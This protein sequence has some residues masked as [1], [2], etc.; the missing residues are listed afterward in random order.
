MRPTE[1]SALMDV[2]SNGHRSLSGMND[3]L[4]D[5]LRSEVGRHDRLDSLTSMMNAAGN[6]TR[7]RILYLLWRN[8]EVRVNDLASILDVTTPAIS[9]QLKKLRA[10]RL[11]RTRRDAQTVYYRLNPD[12][13]F[14]HALIEF[15]H[16]LPAPVS[17]MRKAV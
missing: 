9:Q 1:Q 10:Q 5:A 6:E 16:E 14:V 13:P 15:F 11:V 8:R 12:T 2:S 4:I 17:A 3:Y 7:M